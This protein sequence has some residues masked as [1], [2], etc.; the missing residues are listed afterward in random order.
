[1]MNIFRFTRAEQNS[2]TTVNHGDWVV[3][4]IC[5]TLDDP[6]KTQ[7][8]C[9]DVDTLNGWDSHLDNLFDPSLLQLSRYVI[10]R[11]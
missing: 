9:I 6:S 1:M 7:L 8:L 3:E 10:R 4:A 11:V 5:Q 2:E